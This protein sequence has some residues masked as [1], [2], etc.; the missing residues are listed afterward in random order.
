MYYYPYFYP[1]GY[2]PVNQDVRQ[3]HQP[4]P[5]Y[6]PQYAEQIEPDTNVEEEK[7]ITLSDQGNHPYVVDIEEAAEQNR[8]FRTALWTG[9]HLQVVLMSLRSG[10]DIGLE[11]HRHTDQFLRIEEGHG[12]VQM[13]RER[14]NLNFQRNI[15]ED[16]AIMVP[17][18]TWHNI[19][20]T[21]R[22]PLKLY[23][24]YAPPHHPHGT[25]HRTKAEAKAAEA[26]H[27]EEEKS[28]D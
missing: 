17:A 5:P 3:F 9:R 24:I 11:I 12:L 15:R 7:R 13:G 10:E 20:N 28:D 23:T 14:N 1:Y 21:G 27:R 22:K 8:R 6:L 2:V 25:V 19:I 4:Y 26:G 16:D 18:G